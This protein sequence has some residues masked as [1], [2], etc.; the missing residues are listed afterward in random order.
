MMHH[1]HTREIDNFYELSHEGRRLLPHHISKF[2]NPMRSSR[3]RI[4]T[5]VNT[6][7]MVAKIIKLRIAD[8]DIYNPRCAFDYRISISVECPWEGSESHLSM[9]SAEQGRRGERQ[10]DRMSYRHMFYQIDLTQVNYPEVSI[11]PG[12]RL[13]YH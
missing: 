2:L 11:L 4:T 6:G 3:V 13:M 9:V 5:D 8:F 1:K 12:D 10:K 7:T